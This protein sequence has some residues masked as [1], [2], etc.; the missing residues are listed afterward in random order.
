MSEPDFAPVPPFNAPALDSQAGM[1]ERV[2]A[3]T[4]AYQ[5]LAQQMQVFLSRTD[6]QQ[7]RSNKFFLQ[8]TLELLAELDQ[9]HAREAHLQTALRDTQAQIALL[10]QKLVDMADDSVGAEQEALAIAQARAHLATLL[11]DKLV[12]EFK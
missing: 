7:G 3:P 4:P 1:V 10:K 8:Q 5:N 11:H 12:Q 6:L 2:H 9:H